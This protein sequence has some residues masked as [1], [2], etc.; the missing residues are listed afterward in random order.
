MENHALIF[1]IVL[2]FLAAFSIPLVSLASEKAKAYVVAIV[3][4][5]L[6]VLSVQGLFGSAETTIYAV[7]GWKPVDNIP[8]GIH[9]VSDGL[10]RF[11]LLIVNAMAFFCAVFAIDYIKNYTGQKYFFTLFCLQLAGLNGAV[12]A[13]DMFNLFVFM[14]VTAKASYAL[15]AFGVKKTEIEAS[16]KYQVMGGLASLFLL[17]GITMLYWMTSTLN[18][19]DISMV[20]SNSEID[21]S[22]TLRFIQLFLLAGIG[23]KKQA[24]TFYKGLPAVVTCWWV[25]NGIRT[26]DPQ[27]HNLML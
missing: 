26:H 11:M 16:F 8:I 23:I 2:P 27:N 14:E 21:H 17:F 19:A 12:L 3:S 13:G 5:V 7:G 20:L 24:I 4:L 25:T 15:V 6:M 22:N 18:M 9:L 1:F 10:S